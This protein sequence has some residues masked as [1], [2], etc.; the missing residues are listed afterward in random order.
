MSKFWH[1][2]SQIGLTVLN[3]A[4]VA[5]QVG[6]VIPA[7]YGLIA[8]AVGSAAQTILA[9]IHHNVPQNPSGQPGQVAH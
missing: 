3:V 7:P 4:S 9:A 8:V 6:G 1:V 5:A 2:L